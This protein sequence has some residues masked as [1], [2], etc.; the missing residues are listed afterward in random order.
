MDNCFEAARILGIRRVVYASS[1]AVYGQQHLHGERAVVEDDVR[2]GTSL[3]AVSKIFNE[4]QARLVQP[5]LRYGDYGRASRQHHRPGQDARLN[6]PRA[7]PSA[8][9]PRRAPSTSLPR[10]HDHPLHVE[11]IAEVFVRVTLAAETR[12]AIYNSGG[13]SLSMGQLADTV[14]GFLPDAEIT[15][16]A[17]E[18]G[19][20]ASGLSS[21]TT[22]VSSKSSRS[23]TPPFDQRVIETINAARGDGLPVVGSAP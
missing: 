15:F 9:G 16:E 17:D 18:G 11:D 3:Y 1:L 23:A 8:P 2:L 10:H 20:E 21:W 12:Y 7:L 19:R 4:Y 22:R 5:R 6:E 14:R 13:E